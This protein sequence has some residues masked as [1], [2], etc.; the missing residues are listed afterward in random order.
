MSASS[1]IRRPYFRANSSW[2]STLCG[3]IAQTSAPQSVNV[4]R[5]LEYEQSCFVQTLVSSPG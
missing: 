5:P 1:G 3:L 4:S 2:L